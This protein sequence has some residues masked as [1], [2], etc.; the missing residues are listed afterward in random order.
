[1]YVKDKPR[2][3]NARRRASQRGCA[4]SSPAGDEGSLR[5]RA[6]VGSK[7][8]WVARWAC[9]RVGF[10]WCGEF[11]NYAGVGKSSAR[12]TCGDVA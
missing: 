5:V 9:D 11:G 3:S 6:R 1:M 8:V 2:Q 10:F 7:G 12:G 4:G